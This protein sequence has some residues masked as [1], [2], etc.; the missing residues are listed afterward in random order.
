MNMTEIAHLPADRLWTIGEVAYFLSVPVATLHYWHHHGN[1]P[2]C[3]RIGR[4]L[5]YR[6]E[7][8]QTWVTEQAAAS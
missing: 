2:T 4:H 5:R 1:G 8:V 7:D 3:S 6:A